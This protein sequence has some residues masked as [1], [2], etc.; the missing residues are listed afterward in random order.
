MPNDFDKRLLKFPVS[1]S[2]SPSGIPSDSSQ[3]EAKSGDTQL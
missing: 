2:L 3:H 1:R